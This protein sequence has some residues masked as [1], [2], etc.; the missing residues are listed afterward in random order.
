M[1]LMNARRL[2]LAFITVWTLAVVQAFAAETTAVVVGYVRTAAGAPVAGADI[3]AVSPSA[4]YTARSD[5]QGR[6]T[7]AAVTA[8]TYAISVEKTGSAPQL[9]HGVTVYP[10]S[11]MRLTF[12]LEPRLREI[13]RVSANAERAFTVGA[14]QDAYTVTGAEARGQPAASASGLATYARNTVEGAVARVP[15]VQQDP[16][17]NVVI[18]GGKVD[19]IVFSYDAVPVPQAIVAEPGGNVVGAQLP[20]TGLGYTTLTAGGFA[21][22]SDDALGG[23]IDETPQTGVY[24][25]QTTFAAGLG[26]LSSGRSAELER[27]WATPSLS[28]RYAVDAQLG[29]Q[30]IRYG[31]GHTFYPAE[32][33]TY[34]LGLATRATWSI[35]GNAHLRAGARDDIEL[36]ALAGEATYDQYG[37]PFAGQTFGA[38]D[39]ST[40]TFP[41]APPPDALVNTPTRVRGTY[42]IEK[43]QL[44][45]T[46]DHSY[47]R[48]RLYRSQYGSATSAPFFDDL[49]FPNGVVSYDGRQSGVLTGLGLD[50]KSV[51]SERHQFA[52]GV[53]VRRQ[54]SALDQVVPTLDRRLTSNPVLSSA[55]AF[56]ADEWSPSPALTFQAAL[57]SNATHVSRS[58][59]RRYDVSSLDPHVSA[60]AHLR[61]GA[62]RLAYDHTTVAPKPLQAERLDSALPDAPFVPLAPERG[63]SYEM[64]YERAG[65]HGRVR[66]T[67]FSKAERDRIDVVPVN[68]RNAAA[69]SA[70]PG[71]GIGVP[72]NVGSLLANGAELGFSRGPLTVAATYVHARSSSASQFALNDLNAPAVAANHLFPVG[73]VP[74]LSASATYRLKAGRLTIVP[75]LS[76][77]TGYPFGNGRKVWAYGTDGRTPV[78]VLNDNHVNPGYNYYFL[79]DPALAYDPLTN[80][81]VNSLGTPEGDDPNTLHSAPLVLVSLHLERSVSPRLTLGLDIANLFGTPSPTQLQS[82]PY[83]IGPPGYTGGNAQYAAWYGQQLNGNPYTLGNGVPT[84]DGRHQIVP[85]TYGTGA[86]VPSSYPE[87]R[88]V[89]VT[90]R[91]T[92]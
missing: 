58:D 80:P 77:E 89:Y 69:A 1:T 26:L 75:A 68:F 23:L 25:A 72:Q 92:M 17:A 14:P 34:G 4:R 43:V 21:S 41:G 52:Y 33:A 85:W 18:R 20:T 60:V 45:R 88:S 15:G 31:D 35:S 66:L 61:G 49:S 73:Y 44:L 74:D 10:G 59:S 53:E 79:R 7:L 24:P 29:S 46:Y 12:T 63:D 55:L 87:A 50:A 64:S 42:A 9:Q 27:R 90:L 70:S 47:A 84:N 39:G 67:L 19:D 51:A 86:Y 62:V 6:F 2:A 83:L 5:S 57:R 38:F 65:S 40:G 16:F 13:G 11:T 81:I 30:S 8:D 82:N 76:Y 32:A 36:L 22:A 71:A 3:T 37:T 91:V 28:R 54:T 48:I 78:H 56:L